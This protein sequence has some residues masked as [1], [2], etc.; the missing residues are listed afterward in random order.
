[1]GRTQS[2]ASDARLLAMLDADQ[3]Q[4]LDAA[5]RGTFASPQGKTRFRR[6]VLFRLA[7]EAGRVAMRIKKR[8]RGKQ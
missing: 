7:T 6:Y 3:R 2:K 5:M 4:R 1:M 8:M